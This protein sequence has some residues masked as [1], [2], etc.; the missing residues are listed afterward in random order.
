MRAPFLVQFFFFFIVFSKSMSNN[1]LAPL[2]G[3]RPL[4]N[5]GSTS[6]FVT[7][8]LLSLLNRENRPEIG[9]TLRYFYLCYKWNQLSSILSV[10][11]W[12]VCLQTTTP[13]SLIELI[14]HVWWI[15]CTCPKNTLPGTHKRSA[16]INLISAYFFNLCTLLAFEDIFASLS[17]VNGLHCLT[18]CCSFWWIECWARDQSTA[19]FKI[20]CNAKLNARKHR[21]STWSWQ[22][23]TL[24]KV[25]L[26]K[27]LINWV[28]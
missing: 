26:C 25:I 6:V 9:H 18:D 23:L 16:K 4:R 17:I 1:R 12:F 21:Y 27:E 14:C 24:T 7:G 19:T 15:R 22:F 20:T 13:M 3:L 10:N 2:W 8:W 5:P 28:R 11:W